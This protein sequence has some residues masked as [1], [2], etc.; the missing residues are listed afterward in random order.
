M[1]WFRTL[2]IVAVVVLGWNIIFQWNQD[3]GQKVD[4]TA[5]NSLQ[6]IQVDGNDALKPQQKET[7]NTGLAPQ[8]NVPTEAESLKVS[9]EPSSNLLNVQT[10]LFDIQIDLKGGDLVHLALKKYPRTVE[11]QNDPFVMLVSNQNAKYIAESG[12]IGTSSIDLDAS[13]EQGRPVFTAGQ[14]SYKIKGKSL[15]VP[16]EYTNDAGISFE[17]R[18]IFTKDSYQVQVE[19]EI[20]NGSDSSWLGRPYGRL[21]RT[22]FEDPSKGGGFGLPIFLGVAYWD[23]E[24]NFTKIKF[25]DL[26]ESGSQS[27]YLSKSMTGGWIGIL[28]HYFVAAW[29]PGEEQTNLYRATYNENM[30]LPGGREYV[31]DAVLPQINVKPGETVTS[32]QSLYIGPKIQENLKAAAPGLNLSVDYGPLFFISDILMFTLSYI[33]SIIGNYGFSIILLTV[34]IKVFLFPLSAKG[35]RSMAKM[36]DMQPKMVELKK[37]FGDDRQ[38]MSQE[39]MKLYQKDG[40]NPLGGCLPMLLQMPIFL[41]LYWALLESVELRQAPF[42][43]WIEDLSLMD[44]YFIL[45]LLMGVTMW[46]QQKLNPE[47]PDPMQAKVMKFMPIAMTF[48]FLFFPAGLVLYWVTNNILSIA[49]QS[50]ITRQ[51]AQKR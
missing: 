45:P 30:A 34:L 5:E 39:M 38:K 21:R 12:I 11:H 23:A 14:G 27:A 28:Q 32:T 35:Y 29:T 9:T 15:I 24:D 25:E 1:D 31:V 22:A 49:Q 10:D 51:V 48:L 44:P 13:A 47:P 43:L 17:K 20:K 40:V 50:Y 46:F 7:I 33:Y 36:R 6:N 26:E 3:Y 37:K 18:Y 2:L 16:L 4:V 19:Y 42:I 8:G 41:A